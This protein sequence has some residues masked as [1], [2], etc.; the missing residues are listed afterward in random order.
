MREKIL[1]ER[2]G[3]LKGSSEV[4]QEAYHWELI[5]KMAVR[6][7]VAHPYTMYLP[8]RSSRVMISESFCRL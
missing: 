5:E 8:K 1:I 4:L 3:F 7:T 6:F 2:E